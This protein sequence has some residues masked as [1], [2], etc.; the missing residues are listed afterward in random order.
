M[1][2]ADV[3]PAPTVEP[4]IR[5]RGRRGRRATSQRLL[6]RFSIVAWRMIALVL[7][8]V[9]WHLA[10]IPAGK[11]LL[12]SPLDVLPAFIDMLRSGQLLTA[13]P[14]AWACFSPATRW[15]SSPAS[16]SAC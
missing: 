3:L 6:G 4:P 2:A 8:L 11:L 7:F 10:S 9:L 12:P 16:P 1:S 13:T 14:A 5:P 15:R